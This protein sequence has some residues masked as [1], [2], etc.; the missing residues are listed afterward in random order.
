MSNVEKIQAAEVQVQQMQDALTRL[1]RLAV[2]PRPPHPV[3]DELLLPVDEEHHHVSSSA[4]RDGATH[5]ALEE[6]AAFDRETGAWSDPARYRAR[7]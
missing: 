2:A 3:P 1:P 7:G 5:H 4:A 6:A